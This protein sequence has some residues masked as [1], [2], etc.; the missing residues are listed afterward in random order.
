MTSSP[1]WNK[2][3]TSR[4]LLNI[5]SNLLGSTQVCQSSNKK[6]IET[7][8]GQDLGC[9]LPLW[10]LS[11]GAMAPW[12]RARGQRWSTLWRWVGRRHQ[13][14]HWKRIPSITSLSLQFAVVQRNKR[15]VQGTCIATPAGQ[16]PEA[17]WWSASWTLEHLSS[18]SFWTGNTNWEELLVVK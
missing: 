16:V 17:I 9:Y 3:K 15:D 11:T 13:S 14:L 12:P 18:A 1:H 4:V 7:S 5:A 2:H 10:L 8:P 6:M